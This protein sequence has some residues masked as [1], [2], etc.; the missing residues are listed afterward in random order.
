M[1]TITPFRW[2]GG[3]STLASKILSYLP[4]EKIYVEPFCGS[5]A[6][7]F[8][9]HPSPV[10]VLNDLDSN[11]VNLFRVLQDK[12]L[13]KQLED[14]IQWTLY[15]REEFIKALEILHTQEVNP[16]EKAWAFYVTQN[17]GV[18]GNLPKSSGDWG[19]VFIPSGNKATT[20]SQWGNRQQ[21]FG[22]WQER[23]MRVQIDR[24]D[25]LECIKYWDSPETVF[26]IDPPY[27]ESTR[28]SGKYLHETEDDFHTNLCT[29]LLNLQGKAVLSGY[30]DNMTYQ[31]LLENGWS[32][33]EL[34]TVCRAAA[35]TRTSGLKGKGKLLENQRRTECLWIKG[36]KKNLFN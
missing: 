35:Q 27:I 11:I 21:L 15:S 24:I 29:I 31:S 10:E 23:L 17:Q 36:T 32:L 1:K 7:L 12:D 3:K 6:L 19:R 22:E 28:K 13:Y 5:A 4:E 25:A 33:V 20:A 9:K 14:K 2:M 8:H 18:G 16:V 26:Y 34:D 30:N